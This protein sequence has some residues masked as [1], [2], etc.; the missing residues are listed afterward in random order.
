M[1]TTLTVT[2]HAES[3]ICHGSFGDTDTG[4]ATMIR[5]EPLVSLT[6]MPRVPCVSGNALRG[7]LRRLVM[8]EMFDRAGVSRAQWAATGRPRQWDRLYAALA[9]GGHLDGSEATLDPERMRRDREAI[10]PLSAFGAA[11]YTHMISGRLRSAYAWP[12]CRETVAA[13]LCPGPSD[14]AAEDLVTEVALV[15][16]VDR[17]YQQPSES[18]VTPM[19][20]TVEALATGTVLVAALRFERGTTPAESGAVAHGLNLLTAIGGKSGA[21]LGRVRVTH[22]GD[23]APYLAWLDGAA[24]GLGLVLSDLAERLS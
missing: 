20:T 10:V 12:V 15:R 1:T 18:G 7:I 8:R 13:G 14:V 4:N 11:L 19:P 6:G 2:M 16:H 17:E 23:A 21:G 24:A 22:D 5:R 9:N 3:P